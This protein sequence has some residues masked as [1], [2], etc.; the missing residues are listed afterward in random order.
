MAETL[1]AW[2]A[3][4]AAGPAR[5]RERLAGRPVLLFAPRTED[6]VAVGPEGDWGVPDRQLRT[7]SGVSL[8]VLGHGAPMAAVVEK[9]RE[10]AFRERITLGRTGN[11]DVALDDPSVSRFHAWLERQAEGWVLVDAGSRNG[12]FVAGRRLQPREPLVLTNSVALRVG[13]VQLTFYSAAGFL[14][15]LQRQAR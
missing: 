14:D 6:G 3:H 13:A 2:F 1:L 7:V 4:Y 10:N 11:N 8:P 15:F 5:L 12:T 9:T